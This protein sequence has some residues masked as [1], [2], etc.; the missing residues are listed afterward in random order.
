VG[1][2][3]RSALR[4]LGSGAL[5][6]QVAG[7]RGFLTSGRR[8]LNFLLRYQSLPLRPFIRGPQ[9]H[10]FRKGRSWSISSCDRNLIECPWASGILM[11]G[12]SGSIAMTS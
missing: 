1:T 12:R 9:S 10:S 11:P 3:V 8:E 4:A 7:V 6:V 2:E 5:L